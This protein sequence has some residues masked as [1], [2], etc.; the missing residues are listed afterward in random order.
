MEVDV[1]KFETGSTVYVWLN[2]MVSD[3]IIT[4]YFDAVNKYIIRDMNTKLDYAVDEIDIYTDPE[5]C[6]HES[7]RKM[8]EEYLMHADTFNSIE[9]IFLHLMASYETG[10]KMTEL[11]KTALMSRASEFFG[12]DVQSDVD[13]Y[14]KLLKKEDKNNIVI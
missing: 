7:V 1:L 8:T 5:K 10:H 11:E 13:K 9:A 12:H 3:C 14:V 6:Q 2:N 4:G